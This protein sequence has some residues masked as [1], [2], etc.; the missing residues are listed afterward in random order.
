VR[1]GGAVSVPKLCSLSSWLVTLDS[2]GGDSLIVL[3]LVEAL[4]ANL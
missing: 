1:S 2:R 3:V 4:E